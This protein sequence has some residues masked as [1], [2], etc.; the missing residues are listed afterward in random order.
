M[1][2]RRAARALVGMTFHSDFELDRLLLTLGATNEREFAEPD[3]WELVAS[4]DEWEI[5]ELGP[6]RV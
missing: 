3:G 1:R 4:C 5:V 2:R 6:A